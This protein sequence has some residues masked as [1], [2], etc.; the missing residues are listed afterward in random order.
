MLRR[1]EIARTEPSDCWKLMLL[2][3]A[4][5]FGDLSLV[6]PI[7]GPE[8]YT[9]GQIPA[10]FSSSDGSIGAITKYRMGEYCHLGYVFLDMK[11]PAQRTP[12]SLA[13]CTAAR[14][15]DTCRRPCG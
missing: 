13:G 4:V 7:D 2:H 8:N 3:K 9:R 15:A 10:T 6:V 12:P 14:R 5:D 1:L 11:M